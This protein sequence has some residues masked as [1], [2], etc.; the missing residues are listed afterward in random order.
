MNIG[1]I[2]AGHIGKTLA[3]EL[4]KTGYDVKVANSRGPESV[5]PSVL[6]FGAR[7][8]TIEQAVEDVD[9]LVLSIPLNRVPEIAPKLAALQR[10]SSLS[11]RPTTIHCAIP[12]S[13][14][15]RRAKPRASGYPNSLV[16]LSQ[17]LGMP[18]GPIPSPDWGSP[19]VTRIASPYRLLQT[20]NAIA[21]SPWR[22]WAIRDSTRSMPDR[23]RYRGASSRA[24]PA[25]AR[26]SRPARCPVPW[27]P[28]ND[29][30][31]RSGGTCPSPRFRRGL[32]IRR[33][34]PTRTFSYV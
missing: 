30:A 5:D 31:C 26:T 19:R 4:S 10:T 24:R 15:S 3:L 11:I 7:A 17:R 16:G 14:T 1:I 6:V 27:P 18:S 32:A 21:V 34:I 20:M 29:P 22:L 13:P 12:R 23:L 25:I 33:A 8:V 9:V 2:G 28:R